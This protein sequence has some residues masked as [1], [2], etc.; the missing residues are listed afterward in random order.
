VGR[1]YR[2]HTDIVHRRL[3]VEAE[4]QLRYTSM[5]ISQVAWHLGFKDPGYFSRFFTRARGASPRTFRNA[6]GNVPTTAPGSTA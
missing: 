2:Q 1:H 4:R 5:S 6:P 3:L